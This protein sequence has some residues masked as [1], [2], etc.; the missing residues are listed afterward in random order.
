MAIIDVIIWSATYS[1]C[2]YHIAR[3]FGYQGETLEY[4]TFMGVVMGAMRGLYG[5][6]L[7]F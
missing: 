7:L 2:T 4:F 5:E 6:E 3:I 1:F